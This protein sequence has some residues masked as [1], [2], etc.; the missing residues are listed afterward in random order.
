MAKTYHLDKR[1]LVSGGKSVTN[2][3]N[4]INIKEYIGEVIADG[5][6]TESVETGISALAGGGQ[7]TAAQTANH[8]TET[9]SEVTSVATAADSVLLPDA[10]VGVRLRIKNDGDA[11]LAVFPWGSVDTINDLTNPISVSL[12]VGAD[13]QFTKVDAA[14][15]ETAQGLGVTSDVN[16]QNITVVNN[17][18]TTAAIADISSTSLTTGELLSLTHTNSAIAS[19]GSMLDIISTGV[20]TTI[21]SGALLNLVDTNSTTSRVAMISGPAT[22]MGKVVSVIADAITSGTGLSVSSSSIIE[23]SG[24]AFQ[25]VTSGVNTA[26]TTGAAFD[27]NSSNQLTGTV[28]NISSE[29]TGGTA[30][31]ITT[32]GTYTGTGGVLAVNVN[33]ISSGKGINV[34]GGSTLS[35]WGSLV[36][37][38]TA[39]ATTGR[40][41]TIY[42]NGE[43]TGSVGLLNIT[44]SLLTTGNAL[45]IDGN[46][47]AVGGA[48]AR[49]DMNASVGGRGLE[50]AN[51]TTVSN[52]SQTMATSRNISGTVA[53]AAALTN[54]A[55]VFGQTVNHSGG[56]YVVTQT[57]DTAGT[58]QVNLVH[59][60]STDTAAPDVFASTG[61]DINV[62]ATTSTSANADLDVSARALDVAYTLT[63]TAGTLRWADTDIA[64]IA[65]DNS[66]AL[67]MSSAGAFQLDMLE[68]N[69]DAVT[70]ND[71]N[72]TFNALNI[73][74]S[75]ATNT[76]SAS[77]VGLRLNVPTTFDSHIRAEQALVTD[78]PVPTV[79]SGF[80]SAEDTYWIPYGKHGASGMF[81]TEFYVDLTGVDGVATDLDIIGDTAASANASIGQITAAVQGTVQAITMTCLEVPTGSNADVDLY[82]ANEGTTTE[83]HGYAITNATETALL[84]SGGDWTLGQTKVASAVPPD[85]DYLYLVTG[86]AAAAG[87]YTAGQFLIKIYGT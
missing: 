1:V 76:S 44:A 54:Y 42:N 21:T 47:V 35:S 58:M 39:G 73:D 57:A 13:V 14:N 12:P 34:V 19:G 31:N 56:D 70:L 64:R 23:N 71:A 22:T 7:P 66:A 78:M 48:L 68:I 65:M 52:A 16:A 29:L 87:T 45:N 53:S 51:S 41:L 18:A 81:V 4:Y 40:G 30:L 69:A 9:Y 82:S 3:Q 61:L 74:A 24:S 55:S 75:A 26:A 79:G 46:S 60:L 36:Y 86:S 6:A 63:E 27:I 33:G 28:A 37:V 49:L 5:S 11:A 17:A 84:T 80:S 59:S 85:N 72:I 67:A 15:W 10:A 77:A 38:D 83:T 50:I 20:N 25:V 8:I 2:L 62:T 32:S 43:Y